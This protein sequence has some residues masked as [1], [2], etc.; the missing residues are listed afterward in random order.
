[1]DGLELVGSHHLSLHQGK[2]KVQLF[3]TLVLGSGRGYESLNHESSFS[4]RTR[5]FMYY[6]HEPLARIEAVRSPSPTN[7]KSVDRHK[8]KSQI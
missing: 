2:E 8:Q 4:A 7:A 3:K 1:M 5:S 6:D